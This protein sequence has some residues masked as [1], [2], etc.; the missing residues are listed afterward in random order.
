MIAKITNTFSESLKRPDFLFNFIIDNKDSM[1][2]IEE[3][4]LLLLIQLIKNRADEYF[5][6]EHLTHSKKKRDRNL[7]PFTFRTFGVIF[8]IKDD[9][10][11]SQTKLEE[12]QFLA[13]C[14]LFGSDT[15]STLMQK[16]V[17]TEEMS[18]FIKTINQYI[19]VILGKDEFREKLS[20]FQLRYKVNMIDEILKS[21]KN[22]VQKYS[23][24]ISNADY[25][26]I[27][28]FQSILLQK[29]NE[30]IQK[31][32]VP[33]GDLFSIYEQSVK[34]SNYTNFTPTKFLKE[35]SPLTQLI[36]SSVK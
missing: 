9:F 17:K 23:T 18:A 5:T 22:I 27:K 21:I 11:N 19:T 36:D 14:K 6:F 10:L 34:I 8:K 35:L 26:L 3:R 33:L 29:I 28:G 20:H 30:L 4:Q 12:Y 7:A 24:Q 31:G 13:L 32:V 15:L 16:Y 25:E 1:Q 2:K